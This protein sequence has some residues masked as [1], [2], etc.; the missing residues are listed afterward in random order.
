[1]LLEV[2]DGAQKVGGQRWMVERNIVSVGPF[3]AMFGQCLGKSVETSHIVCA[4]GVQGDG[5]LKNKSK[6]SDGDQPEC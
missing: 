1:M 3:D 4:E 2:V 5:D 6:R